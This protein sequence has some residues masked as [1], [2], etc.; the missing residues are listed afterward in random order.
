MR[1]M[2]S[3]AKTLPSLFIFKDWL[4]GTN[5]PFQ[6]AAGLISPIFLVNWQS[7]VKKAHS[8]S[9]YVVLEAI[10]TVGSQGLVV[11]A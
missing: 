9:F 3:C 2:G 10:N 4:F 11:K 8:L 6:I 5:F 7:G 1:A